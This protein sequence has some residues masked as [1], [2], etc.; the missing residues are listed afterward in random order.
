MRNARQ[1]HV[2]GPG[3]SL[4]EFRRSAVIVAIGIQAGHHLRRI[5]CAGELVFVQNALIALHKKQKQ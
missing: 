1:D 2:P 3:M 5:A 4:D